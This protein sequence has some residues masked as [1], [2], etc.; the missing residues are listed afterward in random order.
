MM[1]L[2]EPTYDPTHQPTIERDYEAEYGDRGPGD[3]TRPAEVRRDRDE[4]ESIRP[5]GERDDRPVG[6][7]GAGDQ[8]PGRHGAG[9]REYS[10]QEARIG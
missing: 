4:S 7:P 3:G 5:A 2:P 9:N 6:V 10:G 8:D 1:E